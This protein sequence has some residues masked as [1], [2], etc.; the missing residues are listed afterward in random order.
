MFAGRLALIAVPS[1]LGAQDVRLASR[2]DAATSAAVT[3]VVDSARAA[4]LPTEPLVNKALEGAAKGSD[5]SKIVVAVRQLAGRMSSSRQV[6]G[7]KSTP[8]EISAAAT[9]LDA[10][11]SVHDLALLRSA[12]NKRPLTVPLAALTDLVEQKVP[13]ATAS[14]VVLSLTRSGIPDRE[15][16]LFQRNVRFDIDRGADPGTAASTRARGVLLRTTTAPGSKPV[17]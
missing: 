6:L 16:T 17:R 5:G 3:A 14:N 7:S 12:A 4:K 2:L 13:V 1:L 10:G 11:V 9:A 8:A 15:F